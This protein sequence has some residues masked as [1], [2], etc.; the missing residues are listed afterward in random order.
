MA[1]PPCDKHRNLQMVRV[2]RESRTSQGFVYACPVPS[3]RRHHDDLGYFD[4]VEGQGVRG[5]GGIPSRIS[6]AREKILMAIRAQAE[7]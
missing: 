6:S 7:V 1:P 5:M 4:L 2:S 3:C